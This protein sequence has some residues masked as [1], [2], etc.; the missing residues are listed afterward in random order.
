ME[1]I[2]LRLYIKARLLNLITIEKLY[3]KKAPDIAT[4]PYIVYKFM[5]C[6]YNVRDR[7]DWQ[8]EIDYWDDGS[9]D[10]DIVQQSIYVKNGR[11]SY[12]G[13]NKS[14]QTEAE[15]FYRCE[16]EFESPIEDL[17]PNISRFNQRYLLMVD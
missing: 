3:H 10:T 15:G 5:P 12:V 9:D 16:I 7:K 1:L 4:P 8:L 6:N 2:D 13:L 11:E 14:T 17:E